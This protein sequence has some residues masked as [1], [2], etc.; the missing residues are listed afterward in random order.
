VLSVAIADHDVDVAE[1]E[2]SA[3][4]RA[5]ALA[6]RRRGVVPSDLRSRLELASPNF[7]VRGMASLIGHQLKGLSPNAL[8]AD[9]RSSLR[10]TYEDDSA[11]GLVD[12]AL[13]LLVEVGYGK[14][15]GRKPRLQR[16]HGVQREQR[17]A[18]ITGK[19]ARSFALRAPFTADTHRSGR[20]DGVDVWGPVQCSHTLRSLH[21]ALVAAAGGLWH[22]RS[23]NG[24]A[25]FDATATELATLHNGRLRQG[26]KEIAEVLG[27]LADLAALEIRASVDHRGEGPPSD[28]HVIPCSPIEAVERRLPGTDHWVPLAEYAAAL[29]TEDVAAARAAIE[30][31]TDGSAGTL[32]IHLAPWFIDEIVGRHGRGPVLLSFD[33]WA[34]LRPTDRRIYAFLQG[35]N[36]SLR[37]RSK[38]EFYLAEELRFTLAGRGGR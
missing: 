26:G 30:A 35:K 29:D 16:N 1:P 11:R 6:A 9:E 38:V 24:H 13:K 3:S 23:R 27:A 20:M 33:I 31:T 14:P 25:F 21:H 19:L 12:A 36:R 17:L 18:G 15:A 34:H 4:A 37:D 2:N 28:A 10:E 32:R 7:V 5:R 22:T 8:T